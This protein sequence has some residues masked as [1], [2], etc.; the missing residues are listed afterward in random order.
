M[1]SDGSEY[2]YMMEI[3]KFEVKWKI[4]VIDEDGRSVLNLNEL[5][6]YNGMLMANI[7][8]SSRIAL[9]NL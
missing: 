1:I 3:E 2:I 5:E 7:Y 8:M 4:K 9:I 6:I